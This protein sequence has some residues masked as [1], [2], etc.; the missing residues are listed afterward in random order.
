MPT[1]LTG[2]LL[3]VA[4]LLPGFVYT[5]IV[6]RERPDYRPSALHEIAA[7]A[8][9]S[10]LSELTVLGAFAVIHAVRPSWTPDIRTLIDQ[11]RD[12]VSEHY[13]AVF[14]WAAGLLLA[15]GL[16]AAALAAAVQKLPVHRSIVSSWW[17][18]F[19]DWFPDTTRTVQCELDDGSY[20]EGTLADWNSQAEDS[21][22]RD[23]ILVGPIRYRPA[24][25]DRY[26]EHPVSTV[27]V[28]ARNIRTMFVAYSDEAISARPSSGAVGA[29]GEEA[30]SVAVQESAPVPG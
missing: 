11:P 29:A 27:C 23:L 18:L 2:L 24:G 1:T 13:L 6:R 15:A 5:A 3:F 20:V 17:T 30:P 12:Y 21:P 25:S 19:K 22:D 10:V 14:A 9:A 8:L 4:L 28:A 16:L 26:Y 7:V